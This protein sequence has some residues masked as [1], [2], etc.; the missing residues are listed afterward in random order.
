MKLLVP[1]LA[2][3]GLTGCVGYGV[4][5]GTAGVYYENV[6]P[7][8]GPAYGYYEPGYYGR[9]YYG[10][11]APY[12]VDRRSVQREALGGN[13]RAA[14]PAAPSPDRMRDTDRDG[15]PDRFDRDRDG[16]G[17]PNRSDRDFRRR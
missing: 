9:G 5:Y 13:P 3:A 16:D 12:I 17:V 15:V 4:P 10:W 1:L 2:V 14:V 11:T 6:T 8:Y 7:Y